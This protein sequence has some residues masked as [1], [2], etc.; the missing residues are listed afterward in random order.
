MFKL[1]NVNKRNEDKDSQVV[2]SSEV[3]KDQVVQQMTKQADRIFSKPEYNQQT[4]KTHYD[5]GLAHKRVKEKSFSNGEVVRDPYTG[6]ELVLTTKE[7]KMRFG[8]EWQDHLAEA[9]HIEPLNQLAKRAESNPWVTADDVKEIGN[10]PENFQ[11]IS[12]RTNQTGNKGGDNQK[13]WSQD[14]ERMQQISEKTGESVEDISERV[15]QI[16]E[17]AEERN[18]AKLMKASVKNIADTANTAGKATAIQAGGTVT[19]IS[20]INNVFLCIK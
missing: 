7:A 18:S 5:D 17:K 19:T 16:G 2:I 3:A 15:R 4:R 14:Y 6:A 11:V 13:E 8:N 9:D 10:D 20:G 1:F 12:R